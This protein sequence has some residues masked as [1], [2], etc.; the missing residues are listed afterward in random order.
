VV[1][2]APEHGACLLVARKCARCPHPQAVRK[3]QSSS[4]VTDVSRS[5]PAGSAPLALGWSTAESGLASAEGLSVSVSAISTAAPRPRKLTLGPGTAEALPP[6]TQESL[7]WIS[8]RRSRMLAVCST[9]SAS[10][11]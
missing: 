10:V 6:V 4:F 11:A 3:A 2:N 8:T 5:G 1:K 9:A 7:R